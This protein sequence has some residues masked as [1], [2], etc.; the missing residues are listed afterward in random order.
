MLRSEKYLY[1][2]GLG[3]NEEEACKV[4]DFFNYHGGA[5]YADSFGEAI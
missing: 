5:V 4:Y 2:V 1:N 3:I